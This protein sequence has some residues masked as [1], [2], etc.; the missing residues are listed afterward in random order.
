MHFTKCGTP[1]LQF[2]LWKTCK[3]TRQVLRTMGDAGRVRNVQIPALLHFESNLGGARH[4][5]RA[6]CIR[7]RRL[8][9]LR[10]SHASS[11]CNFGKEKGH[12]MS[13]FFILVAFHNRTETRRRIFRAFLELSPCCYLH[14]HC[15]VLSWRIRYFACEAMRILCR[16]KWCPNP[17]RLSSSFS[18]RFPRRRLEVGPRRYRAVKKARPYTTPLDSAWSEMFCASFC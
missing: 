7:C 13:F 16:Q 1:R 17:F 6:R 11:E 12:T 9:R 15:A 2:S 4:L 5:S 18:K 10:F 14:V 8:S 3:T